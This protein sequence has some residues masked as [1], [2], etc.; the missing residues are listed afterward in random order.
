MPLDPGARRTLDPVELRRQADVGRA[1]IK[2]ALLFGSLTVAVLVLWVFF[3]K[4]VSFQLAVTLLG[5]V[6]LP[7]AKAAR[8]WWQW[9]Q[10]QPGGEWMHPD[11][12]NEMQQEAVRTMADAAKARAWMT[13][14]LI[15]CITVPSVL[16]VFVG[17]E[18]AVTVASVESKAI[19][20][21]DEDRIVPLAD[22]QLLFEA[23]PQPKRL[24]VIPGADH[25]DEALAEGPALV[26]AIV[27]QLRPQG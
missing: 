9:R 27:E 8:S 6:G 26:R 25:N 23:A 11:R 15:A 10:T 18:H 17:V 2:Q 5:A 21:G 14:G 3:R 7:A 19:L 4:A 12:L 1:L 20:A 16:E 24:V 22:T 13:R